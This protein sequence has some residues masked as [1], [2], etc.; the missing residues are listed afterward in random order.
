MPNKIVAVAMSKLI[1]TPN[2]ILSIMRA[3]VCKMRMDKTY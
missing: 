3:P 1:A 2:K